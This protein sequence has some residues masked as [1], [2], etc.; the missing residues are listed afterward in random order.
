M[1]RVFW[2]GR[3]R[4]ANLAAL[5]GRYIDRLKHYVPLRVDEV[6][7][8]RGTSTGEAA[9]QEGT[10]FL[11]RLPARASVIA[12]DAAGRQFTSPALSAWLEKRLAAGG[13]EMVFILGGHAGLSPAVTRRADQMLSLTTMTLTHEMARVVFL[14]QLY[15]AFTIMRGENYHH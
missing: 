13:G 11:K 14:E 5:A 12:L 2:A 4:D 9:Q 8:G 3:T 7:A 6:P 10:R 1:L 15:R